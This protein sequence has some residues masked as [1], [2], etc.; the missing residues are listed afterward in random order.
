MAYL[1]KALAS[2]HQQLSIYEKEFLALIMAVE[3]WRQYL[4]VQEFVIRTDH[5]SLTYLTDQNLHS[6]M[7]RRAMTHLMGLQFKVVYRKGKENVAADALSRMKHLYALQAVSSVQPIWI[8]EML[9]SY[10]TDP[11]AGKLLEHLAIQSPNEQGFSLEEGIIKHQG[12]LWVASNSALQTKLIDAFHSSPATYYRLKKL[13]HWKGMKGD[14]EDFI[15]S[16]L[17]VSRPNT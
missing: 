16:V 4:Q 15:N 1:S 5:K 11:K 2:Q 17:F 7:Q 13:F 9:N 12:K 8:Q 14:V 10:A 3:K 6:D